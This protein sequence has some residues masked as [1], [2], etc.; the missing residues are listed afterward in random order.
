NTFANILLIPIVY[1]LAKALYRD[2]RSALWSALLIALSPFAVA[3]SA[4]AFTDVLMLLFMTLALWMAAVGRWGW[5]GMWLTLAFL[6]KPQGLF[7]LP[8][9]FFMGWLLNRLSLLAVLR[10]IFPLLLGTGALFLWDNVRDQAT[11]MWMLGYVNSDPQL[12]IRSDEVLPRL[13][14]WLSFARTLFG[15]PT[16]IFALVIPLS[17]F[18]RVVRSPRQCSTVIDISLL[19]LALVYWLLHWLVAFN[20]YD[21]YLLPLLPPLALL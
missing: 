11:S 17:V 12:L 3:F 9:A 13:L 19:T 7:Y 14:R 10:F 21:R 18:A 8:L 16:P 5:S 1:A 4:T 15:T 6:N 20:T 2:E